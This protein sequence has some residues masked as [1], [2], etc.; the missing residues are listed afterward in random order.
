MHSQPIGQR[1][2]SPGEVVDDRKAR[3]AIEARGAS[4]RA[5][6]DPVPDRLG[7]EVSQR[8]GGPRA[9][10]RWLVSSPAVLSDSTRVEPQIGKES[11]R[12]IQPSI[13]GRRR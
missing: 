5:F 1:D 6:G 7:I 9:T 12:L 3:L 2:P 11:S 8:G 10:S 13:V 4:P